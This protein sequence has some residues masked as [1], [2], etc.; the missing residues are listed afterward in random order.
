MDKLLIAVI[1]AKAREDK[2]WEIYFESAS[3]L[4]SAI[5]ALNAL[6]AFYMQEVARRNEENELLDGVIQMFI[7]RVSSI[8]SNMRTKVN[9]V[10]ADG[11]FDDSDIARGVDSIGSKDGNGQLAKNVASESRAWSFFV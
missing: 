9:D 1:G 7:E 6:R 2:A 10:S 3:T 11:S 5:D 4:N 8:D